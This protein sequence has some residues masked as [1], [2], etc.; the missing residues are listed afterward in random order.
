VAI[1]LGARLLG[2]AL[3]TL[4]TT[5]LALLGFWQFGRGFANVTGVV[6]PNLN[7]ANEISRLVKSID[8]DA[9]NLTN[10]TSLIALGAAKRRLQANTDLLTEKVREL[11]PAV[12]AVTEIEGLNRYHTTLDEAWLRLHD[13]VEQRIRAD[14]QRMQLVDWLLDLDLEERIAA[15]RGD[16]QPSRHTL[17]RQIRS[18]LLTAMASEDPRQISRLRSD[19]DALT[20]QLATLSTRSGASQELVRELTARTQGA[21]IQARLGQLRL[22]LQISQTLTRLD[23]AINGLFGSAEQIARQLVEQAELE[24][25]GWQRTSK[26]LGT[27]LLLLT[28]GYLVAMLL[29]SADVQRRIVGRLRLLQSVMRSHVKGD[30][31]PVDT[32][33]DD[34]IADMASSFAYFVNAVRDR[35]EALA[36]A[37]TDADRANRAKGE[38]L[39]NMSHEI[40]TPISSIMGLVHLLQQTSLDQE[41]RE[42]LETVRS[43][44]RSL[45]GV[46]NDILDFSKID[47][48]KL[49]IDSVDFSLRGVLAQMVD[50]I[51]VRADAKGVRLATYCPEEVPDS[52][53]GDPLRLRQV[54]V[55]LTDNAIKFTE[56]GEVTVAVEMASASGAQV[57]LT[58][59]VRD[60]GIGMSQEQ[61][62]TLFDPFTQADTSTTRQYG[63]TG[64]GLSISKRLVEM[65]DGEMRVDSTPDKGSTFAF[66]ATFGRQ[67]AAPEITPEPAAQTPAPPVH[68]GRLLLVEDHSIN[69]DVARQILELGGFHVDTAENGEQAVEVVRSAPEPYDIVLM[70]VQMPVMDGHAATRMIRQELADRDVPIIA[71]TASAHD[72]E[73]RR[74]LA[75][76][77]DDCLAKPYEPEE[78]AA[79]VTRW[80]DPSAA[81]R[82]PAVGAAR[83]PSSESVASQRR[84]LPD[85]LDGI[86]I[87]A[88]LARAMGDETFYLRLLGQFRA[89]NADAARNVAAALAQGDVQRI[90]AIAHGICSTAGAIGATKLAT[91]AKRLETAVDDDPDTVAELVALFGEHMQQVH[92]SIAATGS[93][94]PSGA[95]RSPEATGASDQQRIAMVVEQLRVSLESNSLQADQHASVLGNLLRESVDVQTLRTLETQIWDL[96]YAA[97]LRTLESIVRQVRPKAH[98][99]EQQ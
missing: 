54:L 63:G 1:Y 92:E 5:G 47:A 80:I 19:Y 74:C 44:A 68:G 27:G 78:L 58:F 32:S 17:L 8:S 2:L 85:H 82:E 69:R 26:W 3:L 96:D 4:A 46:V 43:S 77:M 91:T 25:T 37:C 38:F 11:D 72:E 65:M 29:I 28:L 14:R 67:A 34:E 55:N 23:A 13:L 22:E 76:G 66:T 70:D 64:L 79:I 62:A 50:L 15:R 12:V 42:K 95:Q 41:Q 7:V 81:E 51:G 33:G 30:Q 57:Q 48:G 39:A 71:L 59:S 73:R 53:I 31:Q 99:S 45:L 94:A 16:G 24:E 75:S 36:Q 83:R 20:E 97:A 9:R 60:T 18:L 40:R 98:L 49:S 87:R 89:A 10:H 93:A 35:E 90:R 61:L 88:G 84:T 21:D 52:L 86:D 56:A 6:L